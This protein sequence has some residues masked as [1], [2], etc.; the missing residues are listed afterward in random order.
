MLLIP[1][2]VPAK[3]NGTDSFTKAIPIT[4]ALEANPTMLNRT[5]RSHKGMLGRKRM[6]IQPIKEIQ[7]A[8][9]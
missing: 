8:E 4:M 5:I 9:K 3:V 1:E 2:T 6:G 7:R